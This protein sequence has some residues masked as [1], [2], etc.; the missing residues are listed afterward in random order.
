MAGAIPFV[1]IRM[2][3]FDYILIQK[4][5]VTQFM[6]RDQSSKIFDIQYVAFAGSFAGFV[7]VLCVYPFDLVRR[8]QQLNGSSS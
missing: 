7:A 2:S 3:L 5:Q 4:Y 6:G 8:F 1:A